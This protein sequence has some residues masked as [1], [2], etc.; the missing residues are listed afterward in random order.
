M[1]ELKLIKAVAAVHRGTV[2]LAI[3]GLGL[4]NKMAERKLDKQ[5]DTAVQLNALANATKERARTL[6]ISAADAFEET[7]RKLL[8]AE[9]LV[10]NAK[11]D[12]AKFTNN[13]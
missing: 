5:L 4:R 3:A 9:N 11:D 2:N 12:L 13:A 10:L 7:K 6:R 8:A 1:F